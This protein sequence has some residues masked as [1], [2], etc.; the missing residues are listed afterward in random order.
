M[1]NR[2]HHR[3]AVRSKTVPSRSIPLPVHRPA[4]H[5][6][7][8]HYL[9]NPHQC[10]IPCLHSFCDT[11]LP[12]SQQCW[13]RDKQVCLTKHLPCF[14]LHPLPRLPSYL[15]DASITVPL[16]LLVVQLTRQ[17]VIIVIHSL[18]PPSIYLIASSSQSDFPPSTCQ[19]EY[20]PTSC[21]ASSYIT[22]MI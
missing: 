10:P 1:H 15:Y 4:I 9:N 14:F 8:S 16:L 2:C 22:P 7:S 12:L 13:E 17:K 3:D 5:R 18:P 6:I 20:H 11:Y 21:T 19:V